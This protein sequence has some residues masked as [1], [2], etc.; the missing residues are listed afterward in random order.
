MNLKTSTELW[1][2]YSGGVE[3]ITGVAPTTGAGGVGYA[4]RGIGKG[5]FYGNTKRTGNFEGYVFLT[6]H[7][8]RNGSQTGQNF[9]LQNTLTTLI[10]ELIHLS[11]ALSKDTNQFTTT[12]SDEDFGKVAKQLG[13]STV[14]DYINKNCKPFGRVSN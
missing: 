8:Y 6:T 7:G 14:N 4:Y 5:R 9:A 11:A 13:Y 3:S 2:T 1:K 12:Y 10:H